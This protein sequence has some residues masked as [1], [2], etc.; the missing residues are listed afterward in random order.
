MNSF[1][2][3]FKASAAMSLLLSGISLGAE[4]K[5]FRIQASETDA[6]RA[7]QTFASCTVNRNRA[8][9]R[10]MALMQP[11]DPRLHSASSELV[12]D[13][14]L[15][16][17][18]QAMRLKFRSAAM[19][20]AIAEALV[21]KEMKDYLPTSFKTVPALDHGQAPKIDNARLPSAA[22]KRQATLLAYER[23]FH[24]WLVDSLGE[25]A[26][27]LAPSESRKLLDTRLGSTAE[28]ETLAAMDPHFA[29]CRPEG[30]VVTIDE[31]DTRGAVAANYYRLA[32]ATLPSAN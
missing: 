17:R 30:M 18:D 14:C 19:R 27:R 1:M 25:C 29:R 20:Y 22:D 13:K 12:E 32:S 26:V 11:L 15:D 16:V 31:F 23:G 8:G 3:I 28:K 6:R 2:K 24:I 10:Q 9:A 21:H 5:N 4:D 7:M